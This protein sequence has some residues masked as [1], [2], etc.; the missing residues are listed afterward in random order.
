MS[1]ERDTREVARQCYAASVTA[2]APEAEDPT[3]YP[4]ED[5]L[6]EHELKTYILELLRPLIA[7]LLGERG[8]EAHVGSDQFIYW[9]QYAPTECVA[10]DL[11]VLPG[12]PQAI[13]IETWKLWERG[14]V[15]PSFALEV[16]SGNWR[17]DYVD[18]LRKYE[19]LG[20][21]ELITFDPFAPEGRSK[22]S[23]RVPFQVFRREGEQLVLTFDGHTDRVESE[24]LGCFLRVV[25]EG[26][27]RRLRV[28]LGPEGDELFPTEAEAERAEKERLEARVRELERKLGKA[29]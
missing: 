13:A 24:D 20:V 22:R 9:K 4:V 6:G 10:P 23:V 16:V 15:A 5:D 27:A 2:L 21:R 29:Q 18:N 12:V 11:Y 26:D 7:R 17:K 8:V 3:F 14:G 1:P 25:G 28:G 19:R